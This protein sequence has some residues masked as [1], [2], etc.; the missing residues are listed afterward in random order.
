MGLFAQP[1]REIS[2]RNTRFSASRHRY[3][4]VTLRIHHLDVTNMFGPMVGSLRVALGVIADRVAWRVGWVFA[5][6]PPA[7]VGVWIQE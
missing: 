6:A 2:D 5:W 3:D 4:P 1:E 7:L